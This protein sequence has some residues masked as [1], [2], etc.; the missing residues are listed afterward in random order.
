VAVVIASVVNAG[1]AEGGQARPVR[2]AE[3]R[4]GEVWIDSPS[5]ARG[6]FNLKDETRVRR[7]RRSIVA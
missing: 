1:D 3:G 6:Y 4:V 7:E 5:K 2:L